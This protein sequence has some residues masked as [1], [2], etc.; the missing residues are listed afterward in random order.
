MKNLPKI[1]HSHRL[2]AAAL[3]AAV[4]VFV[5]LP[6]FAQGTG[7]DLGL[8]YATAIGLASGDVRTVASRIISYF[9]GLL[10]IVTVLIMLYAGFLWMTSGGSEEKVQT[11]KKWM[12]NGVI[13]LMI[14]MS[15]FAITQFIFRAITGENGGGSSAGSCPPGQVCGGGSAGLGGGGLGGFKITGITPSGSG[16]GDKGWP[17]NYAFQT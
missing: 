4:G 6:A 12:V 17:K 16:S 9:L 13:G 5:A 8:G 2:R 7:A 14:V 10:G 3:T 1:P 15:A 11:A